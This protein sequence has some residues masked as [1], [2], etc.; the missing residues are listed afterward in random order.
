[1]ASKLLKTFRLKFRER[2]VSKQSKRKGRGQ[3]ARLKE[4]TARG[5]KVYVQGL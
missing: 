1:M 2:M 5:A 3:V 4:V